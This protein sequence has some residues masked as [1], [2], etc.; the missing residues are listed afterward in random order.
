MEPAATAL[1][2]AN[3]QSL[4]FAWALVSITAPPSVCH[5][6]LEPPTTRLSWKPHRETMSVPPRRT[7]TLPPASHSRSVG[8]HDLASR[9]KSA[10]AETSA[11]AGTATRRSSHRARAEATASWRALRARGRAHARGQPLTRMRLS[12][13]RVAPSTTK[14]RERDCASRVAGAAPVVLMRTRTPAPL[15]V[16][17]SPPKAYVAPDSRSKVSSPGAAGG[18]GGSGGDCGGSGRSGEGGG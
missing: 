5:P 12:S 10:C 14:W 3:V 18:A 7:R 11:Q 17:C 6:A 15:T 8:A 16:I 4:M 1:L 9:P 2:F 13:S